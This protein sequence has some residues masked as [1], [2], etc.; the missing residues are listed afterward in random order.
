MIK[1]LK[2]YIKNL[3]GITKLQSELHLIKSEIHL[4]KNKD[5][6]IVDKLE[7]HYRWL[8]GINADNKLILRHIKL[9]NSQF[10]V[11]ADIN[12]PRHAPSVVLILHRG[13]EEIVKSYTFDNVTVEHIHSMLEG[14][15]KHNT[16]IDQPRGFPGPRWRY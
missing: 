15:G 16:H 14:F 1:K 11:A 12:H 7:M 13:K 10:Y 8:D 6:S 2:L 4:L 5:K 9:I 3:L